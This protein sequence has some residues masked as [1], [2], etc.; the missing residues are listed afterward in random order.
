MTAHT[1]NSLALILTSCFLAACVADNARTTTG[2]GTLLPIFTQTTP[3]D[4]TARLHDSPTTTTLS[5]ENWSVTDVVAAPDAMESRPT[6]A[7]NATSITRTARQ[8]GDPPSPRSALELSDTT[9]GQLCRES[10]RSPIKALG[11]LVMMP[12]RMY[13]HAPWGT[14][15]ANPLLPYWRA[16]APDASLES[17]PATRLWIETKSLDS[18]PPHAPDSSE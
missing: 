3:S 2:P 6:Y 8:R 4:A 13:Q 10:L 14:P 12:W 15:I 18:A 16:P 9:Y 5:R 1:A 11:D 17:S 7:T